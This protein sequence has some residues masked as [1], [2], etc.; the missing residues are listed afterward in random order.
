MQ[1]CVWVVG[2]QMRL[3]ERKDLSELGINLRDCGV[4]ICPV[5]DGKANIIRVGAFLLPRSIDS[6][7]CGLFD[8]EFA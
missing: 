2:V 7:V 3:G 4:P 1:K 6:H 5:R 8:L